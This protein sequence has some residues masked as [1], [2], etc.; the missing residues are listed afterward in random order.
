MF[1]WFFRDSNSAAWQE[2]TS[3]LPV[4][5]TILL[6]KNSLSNFG[7]TWQPLAVL[8]LDQFHKWHI[9]HHYWGGCGW[10]GRA[11]RLVI[12]KVGGLTKV[13]WTRCRTPFAPDAFIGAWRCECLI[14]EKKCWYDCGCEWVNV[15]CSIKH[16]ECSSKV[17]N[18]C[19][20]TSRFTIIVFKK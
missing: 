15:T 20:R 16:F 18:C 3:D 1:F 8:W 17:E 2:V 12:G 11:G 9:S 13:C 7:R 10:G 14:E 4:H 19:V 5:T 6:H